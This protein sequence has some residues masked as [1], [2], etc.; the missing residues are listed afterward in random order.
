VKNSLFLVLICNIF[1]GLAQ[2]NAIKVAL[3]KDGPLTAYIPESVIKNEISELLGGEYT[4]SYVDNTRTTANWSVESIHKVFD[5]LYSDQSIDFIVTLGPIASHELTNRKSL[6]VATIAA[7]VINP[8]IQNFPLKNSKSDRRNLSFVADLSDSGGEIEFFSEFVGKRKIAV[9]VEPFLAESWN[10]LQ[11]VLDGAAKEYGLSFTQI[12]VGDDLE[13]IRRSIPLD[14]EAVIVGFLSQY[15]QAQ[16]EQLADLLIELRLPSYT[17][18]GERGV[19]L[20][21]MVTQG[22]VEQDRAKLSRRVALN[23]QRLLLG[24]SAEQL[25][26]DINFSSQVIFNERTALMV[27]FAPNWQKIISAKVLFRDESDDKVLLSIEE[28]LKRALKENLSLQSQAIDIDIAKRNAAISKSRLYPQLG[29]SVSYQ[30]INEEQ[31]ILGNPESRG[32]ASLSLSQSLY[33]ESLW[34]NFEVKELQFEIEVESYK[35]A[36]LEIAEQTVQS[37]LQL[38]SAKANETI[39]NANLELTTRNLALARNRMQIGSSGQSDVLRFKSQMAR[40]RQTLF[41]AT[42]ARQ[43]AEVILATTINLADG[44][45]VDIQRPQIGNLLNILT[46]TRFLNYVSNQIEWQTFQEFYKKEA[47]K[48]SPQLKQIEINELI[49][50]RQLLSNERGNYMPDISLVAKKGDNF[51]QS[52]EQALDEYHG[53]SWRLGVEA[54]LS[55]DLSGSRNK[56]SQVQRL[57][58]KKIE[59]NKRA[60]RQQVETSTQQALFAIGSSYPSIQLSKESSK[61]AVD[62]LAIVQDSYAKGAVS[63]SELLDA[64]NNALT[65]RLSAAEAEYRFLSDYV[66]LLKAA[67][68]FSPLLHGQYSADW[69]ERLNKYFKQK[70]IPVS[71]DYTSEDG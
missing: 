32:D 56:T 35:M 17:F 1:F 62:S 37:Y 22:Q 58:L 9:L 8:I 25:P 24:Q 19:E 41:S 52:G 63:I 48:N 53:E 3:V 27:N 65:A 55:F 15:N 12:S 28:A 42:A 57:Q 68:D 60:L 23:I 67:G 26:V 39:Q 54:T 30:Q 20:G 43:Q 64:Q 7:V 47:L 31:A 66:S 33:S 59:L 21:F 14:T 71:K 49:S 6:S 18:M 2:A 46:N 10:E 16:I 38:L 34:A 4:L 51:L 29:L 45:L 40:D 61:A 70:N 5:D 11:L 44:K 36:S 69:F 50:K 13:E